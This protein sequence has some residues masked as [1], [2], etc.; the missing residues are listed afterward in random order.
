MQRSRAAAFRA[1]QEEIPTLSSR[2]NRP[3]GEATDRQVSFHTFKYFRLC[4][5]TFN[6]PTLLP[7]ESNWQTGIFRAEQLH[8]PESISSGCRHGSTTQNIPELGISENKVR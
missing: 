7:S 5:I 6:H 4:K 2:L 8:T 1:H 3:R